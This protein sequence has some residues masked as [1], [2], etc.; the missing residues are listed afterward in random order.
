MDISFHSLDRHFDLPNVRKV[1]T[2]SPIEWLRRGWED[3]GENPLAS[4]AYGVFFTA[5]GYLILMHLADKP[6]L[7]TAAVSG[8]LLVGPVAAAGLY[9]MSRRR[10]QGQPIG[11]KES[12]VGLGRH[13]RNLSY[14][15]LFLAFVLLSWERVSAIL[16]ALFYRGDVASIE[17]FFSI[18]VLSG[19]YLGFVLTYLVVGG[20]LAALVYTLS[21]VSVPMLMDR[22]TDMATAMMTSAQ[23]VAGNLR[24]MMQWAGLIVLLVALGFATMMIAMIVVLPWLGHA[25]WHAYRDLVE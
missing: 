15:G 6:Y 18:V 8:F 22:D 7:A 12:L 25:S 24:P 10:A 2:S 11:L 16:F 9:E 19:D 3:F 13:M 14:F 20:V 1:K 5:L 17:Q 21:A 23:A 4:L